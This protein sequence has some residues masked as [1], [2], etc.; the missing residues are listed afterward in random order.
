MV[1]SDSGAEVVGVRGL[2][3]VLVPVDEHE[4]LDANHHGLQLAW[5]VVGPVVI[6]P[7]GAKNNFYSADEALT[8]KECLGDTTETIDTRSEW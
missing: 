7:A 6:I 2:V 5:L 3:D 8:I 1:D 4:P